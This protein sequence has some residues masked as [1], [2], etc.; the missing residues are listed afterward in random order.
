VNPEVVDLLPG[1]HQQRGEDADGGQHDHQPGQ[2]LEQRTVYVG[3]SD[4]DHDLGDLG[5]EADGE[6]GRGQPDDDRGQGGCRPGRAGE[7]GGQ[8]GGDRAGQRQPAGE[9]VGG[10][11]GPGPRGLAGGD[12]LD[13]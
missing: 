6:D 4:A 2:F 8:P 7:R 11:P 10:A 5:T 9:P 13:G 1:L 12:R 3:D